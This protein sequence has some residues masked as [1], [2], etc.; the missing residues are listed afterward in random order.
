[1]KIIVQLDAKKHRIYRIMKNFEKREK[2]LINAINYG[3]TFG[4]GLMTICIVVLFIRNL[5]F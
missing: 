1:M 3:A 4:L 5:L 2:K